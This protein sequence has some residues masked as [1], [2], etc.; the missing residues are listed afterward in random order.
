MNGIQF[1][2]DKNLP[3]FELK[4][5]DTRALSYKKHSHEEYSLGIVEKGNS[6]FWYGG[7]CEEVCPRSLV[8]I[9]PQLVH[10][11]N[12]YKGMQWSYKMLFID[13]NWVQGL[14]KSK[15]M[16]SVYE[17]VVTG[18]HGI[19][20]LNTVQQIING[21]MI[22][23]VSPL[24]KETGVLAVFDHALHTMKRRV[25]KADLHKDKPKLKL[26]KEYLHN[27]FREKITLDDLER[28]SGVN[29]FHLLRMFKEEFDVPPHMYQTLLRINY[30]K[31]ELRK[32]RHIAEVAL[33][34]G[35]Y[36]QSHFNKVFKSHTGIT[37]E[38][39][40]RLL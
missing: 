3:F 29:K 27:C 19:Q 11:C 28:V 25:Y 10:S 7:K 26:V 21:F 6:S 24:E 16:G 22:S 40:Q 1:Y 9:P 17:P 33:E 30:A 12:P 8:V 31:R 14:V 4:I 15:G 38:R 23:H 2:R 37:P 34:A 13:A 5:C 32:F 39:Y 36:D 18:L 35:F 20:A